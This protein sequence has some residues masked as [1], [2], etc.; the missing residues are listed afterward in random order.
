MKVS[1]IPSTVLS[2]DPQIAL[3]LIEAIGLDSFAMLLLENVEPVLP[4]SHCTI[5]GLRSNGRMEAVASASS[6]GEIATIT[7]IDYMRMGFD[8]QDSN[9]IWLSKR[10]PAGAR[11]FWIGHQFA[12]DVVDEKYRRLCYEEPGIRERL[13]LLSV[14]P[15]GY[16]VSLSFYRNYSYRDFT[17]ADKAWLAQQGPMMAAAVMQHVRVFPQSIAKQTL[18]H[19]LIA[20]LSG[21]ERQVVAHIIEGLTTKEAAAEMG[22]TTATAAT[23]RYRAFHHL[24]VRTL[25]ELFALLRNPTTRKKISASKRA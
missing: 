12:T 14:F 4:S 8:R 2:A 5:F 16:R 10:R 22:V 25:N 20:S 18:E 23:Y 3:R 17:E 6:I 19:D 1:R 13:S 9:T 21:R 11:Q 24:G 7:A 15:D